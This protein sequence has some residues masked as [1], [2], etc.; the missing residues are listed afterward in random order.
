L[1]ISTIFLTAKGE[2]SEQQEK[3]SCFS[4]HFSRFFFRSET[5]MNTKVSMKYF[6]NAYIVCVITECC[7]DNGTPRD[8]ITK[9]FSLFLDTFQ[10][11]VVVSGH[12]LARYLGHCFMSGK[13]IS[14]DYVTKKF[15]KIKT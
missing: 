6:F 14:V 9:S 12:F 2:K 1:N 7:A 15:P 3:Q 4:E 11:V 8:K 13:G 10:V 5:S